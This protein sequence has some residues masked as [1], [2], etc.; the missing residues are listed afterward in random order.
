LARPWTW[1]RS[2]WQTGFSPSAYNRDPELLKL[3]APGGIFHDSSGSAG[4]V[5]TPEMAMTFSAVYDAVNQI[6]SDVAKLPLNLHKRLKTGGSELYTESKTFRLLKH[7][8]NPEMGSMTF[9]RQ[10]MVWALTNKGCLAEIVRDGAG[11]PAELWPI[12]PHRWEPHRDELKGGKLGPLQYLVDGSVK[13]SD[14][15]VVHVAGI[16]PSPHC[17]W[18]LIDLAQTA[19]GLALASERFGAKWFENGSRFGGLLLTDQILNEDQR[20]ALLAA[21]E[22]YHKGSNNANKL[23]V[24]GGGLKYQATSANPSEAQMDELRDR[25]VMEVARFFNMPLH[26]LK[27][28]KEGSVSY[29]SVEMSDL[30]YYKGCLLN[31]ITLWEEEYNRKL[32]PPSESRQQFIKHNANAFLRGDIQSRYN[33]LA[34]ARNNGI[35]NANEWRELEDMNPLPGDQGNLY[36][37]QS[38]FV[39]MDRLQE[40]ADKIA[41]PTPAPQPPPS[42]NAPDDDAEAK[43]A[44]ERAER[45]ETMAREAEQRAAE[46]RDQIAALVASGSDDKA[47]TDRL[48]AAEHAATTQAAVSTQIAEQARAEAAA[49]SA[50]R[51]AERQARAEAEERATA[52]AIAAEA[53]TAAR[54]AADAAHQQ[55]WQEAEALRAAAAEAY[56][57]AHAAELAV[58]AGERAAASA[59]AEQARAYSVTAEAKAQIAEAERDEKAEAAVTAA[60]REAAAIEAEAEAIAERDAALTA[61]AALEAQRAEAEAARRTAEQSEASAREQ[62]DSAR[63]SVTA[64]ESVIATLAERV[65]ELELVEQRSQA[66]AEQLTEAQ[67]ALDEANSALNAA[68]Q[69]QVDAEAREAAVKQAHEALIAAETE[70]ARSGRLLRAAHDAAVLA[71]HRGLVADVVGRMA[72]RAAEQ[73]RAKQATAEKLRRWF[74]SFPAMHEAICLD[75]MLPAVRVCLAWRGVVE[76]SETVTAALVAEHLERFG[77]AI[78]MALDTNPEDFHAVLDRALERWEQHEADRVADAVLAEEIRHVAE[79]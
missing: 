18:G 21:V 78:R 79:S 70:R 63:E 50:E 44:N 61:K 42:N 43:A 13:L 33:A 56:A 32:I 37:V 55:A 27:V 6:S 47:E 74:N 28:N 4:I 77:T 1:L 10:M 22:A 73:A 53:A 23:G 9:R 24:F 72:R 49:L 41:K 12:E 5:V 68:K 54:A 64:L 38:G 59:E 25:Q 39:P 29:A 57:R 75:A 69:A 31:W 2:V 52:L 34:V 8:P 60:L 15:D 17:A 45:A 19:I 20:K 11:R 51:D 65:T 58:V 67:S 40:I 14:R 3:W 48:R 36:I 7:E 16:G 26:K 71:S 30:D 35:I 62:A 76:Q 66:Q 46:L